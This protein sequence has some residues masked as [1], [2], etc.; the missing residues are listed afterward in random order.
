MDFIRHDIRYSVRTLLRSPVTTGVAILSLTLG[1]GANTAIFSL[2]N[3][4]VLR[5]LPIPNPAQ[6]VTLSTATPVNPEREE[7]LSLAMIQQLRKDQRVFSSLFAWSGGGID[8]VEAD[9]VKYVASITTVSGE[10]FAAL[11][12]QPLLGRFIAPSD[13][14]LDS[15][16]PADVAVIDYGCW[17][18]RYNGDPSVLGKTIRVDGHPLTIIGV[19]PESFSGLFIEASTDVVVPIGY[20]GT[21]DYRSRKSLGLNLGARLKPG[22]TLEQARAQVESLWPATL[23]ASLPE[24][25]S[26][27]QRGAFLSRRIMVASG[28]TGTSFLRRQYTRPLL[29]LMGMVG[30]LL[31]IACANLANLMLARAAGR[32]QEFGIRI[33]LGAGKWRIVRQMLTESLMLSATGAVLGLL[34]ANWA[35]RL[36]LHT[37]GNGYV[38]FTLDAAP[39][40]RV[41]SFTSL[42]SLAT[43]LLFGIAPAW[44]AIRADPAYALQRSARTVRGG[45]LKLANVLISAQV[46]LSL[47]LLIGAVLFVRSLHNL[48]SLDLGFRRDGLTI[49]NLFPTAGE[50]HPMPDRV[51]YYQE[52]AQRLQA[53]PGVESVSYSHMGPVLSYEFMQP[54]SA[55]SSEMLPLQAVFEAIGPGFFHLAGMR[56]IAGREFTWR[57]NESAQ[58]VAIVSES[59]ARR[60]F[61]S[62]SPIGRRIDFGNKKNLEIVG[63]V[64]SASLW[65]PQS[66]NPLAVYLALMQ[67]PAY[68]SGSLEIR[69]T[70]DP[71]PLLRT[72]SRAI[73]STGRYLVLRAETLDQRAA[74]FLSTD[75]MIAGLSSFFG[76]LALLLA[77]IGLYGLMSYTVARR[78]AEIGLRMALGAQPGSVLLLVLRDA[79]WLVLAGMA[80]GI[81]ASLAASHLISSMIYGVAGNDP[82]TILLSCS[83]LLAVAAFAAYVP[84]RRATHVDPMSALRSE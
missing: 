1:I 33:A 42:V 55:P 2:M 37:M 76:G 60:L 10:Y 14:N 38:S 71:G 23:E 69:S 81:P 48:R 46:A 16:S 70:G 41:L 54:V 52:L 82:V 15:G 35:S 26:G 32:S 4:V 73:E 72:A 80:A 21:T 9:G 28:A 36:L 47:V 77:S 29:V 6:L 53:L 17:Q 31:L 7:S 39:D 12:I 57:D 3:A 67:M 24:G 40:L 78:N 5:P 68:N 75:R 43:G 45:S 18:H 19:T 51:A 79:M 66:R 11:G 49:F 59:L 30:V 58:A 63:V 8:N 65:L 84:A 62:I 74:Y 34:M 56:L 50:M 64:N 61:P 13:L 44:K 25:Y 83:V 27:A 22:V 20:D